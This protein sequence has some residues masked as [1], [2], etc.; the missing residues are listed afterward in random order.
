MYKNENKSLSLSRYYNIKDIFNDL[1]KKVTSN[2]MS[3]R[4]IEEDLHHDISNS[5]IS[6]IIEDNNKS[7][8]FIITSYN[9]EK[10]VNK[11]IKSVL[12]QNYPFW[13]IIYIDDC[14]ND[15]TVDKLNKIVSEYNI[16][17]KITI[18][19][20]SKRRFQS[21]NRWHASKLCQD[22][23]ICCMLDG[24]DWLV[25]DSEIL[26][27]L[28]K[29]YLNNKLLMSYGQF[30]CYM[31]DDKQLNLYKSDTYSKND[32]KNNN[33]RHKWCTHHLRT[34]EAS[35][36]KTIPEEYLK[37]D[38]DFI[39]V[40]TDIAEMYWCLERSN[41]RHMN[42]GFPTVIY[43]Q[44]ASSSYNNSYYNRNKNIV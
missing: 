21:F 23:E 2:A 30:Y 10:W 34:M 19:K 38:G 12:N 4:Q 6:R 29:L 14:S 40:C 18:I 13:R 9:N 16:S 37:L 17:K 26:Q 43:N 3:I 33:Y 41:G 25:P 27:K 20:N 36:M 32:I 28:N 22:D 35:L 8:V 42:V 39:S 1:Y 24:D 44:L 5:D 7:F 31:G 11:N 15:K